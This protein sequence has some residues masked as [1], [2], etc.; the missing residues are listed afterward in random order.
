[1]ETVIPTEGSKLELI[2]TFFDQHQALDI[3]MG[4]FK[5][6]SRDKMFWTYIHRGRYNPHVR[7]RHGIL[8]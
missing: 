2:S 5:R 3:L 7:L 1:M 6:W 8:L 4:K